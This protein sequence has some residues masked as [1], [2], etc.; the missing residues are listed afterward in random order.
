MSFHLS[1]LG[2][3]VVVRRIEAPSMTPGGIVLPDPAKE[4]PQRGVVLALP[5]TGYEGQIDIG[6]EVLFSKYGGHDFTID[7]EPV[8]LLRKEDL[9]ARVKAGG[10]PSPK[11]AGD[12]KPKRR[13]VKVAS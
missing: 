3:Y 10:W 8:V 6:D 13:A 12:P 2:E 4:K 1:P 7:G 11:A 9:L 5:A